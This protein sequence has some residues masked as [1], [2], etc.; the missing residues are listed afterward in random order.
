M[1]SH[2]KITRSVELCLSLTNVNLYKCHAMTSIPLRMPHAHVH[3]G[4]TM[5]AQQIN[6]P[7]TNSSTL[8]N[9]LRFNDFAVDLDFGGELE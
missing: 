7:W 3:V 1:V 9:Q 4:I 6:Q 5:E 8:L 2:S